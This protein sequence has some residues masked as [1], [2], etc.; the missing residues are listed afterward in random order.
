METAMPNVR[1]TQDASLRGSD[2]IRWSGARPVKQTAGIEPPARYGLMPPTP[3]DTSAVTELQAAPYVSSHSKVVEAPRRVTTSAYVELIRANV[4]RADN[5]TVHCRFISDSEEM[6]V[7][8]PRSLFARDAE[9]H[10]GQ[11]FTVR[12][13]DVD[14]FRRPIVTIEQTDPEAVRNVLDEFDNLFASFER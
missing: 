8:L 5:E 10:Y 7:D 11:P 3:H 2:V 1:T 12:M 4:L 6:T 14:G 9:L 13:G